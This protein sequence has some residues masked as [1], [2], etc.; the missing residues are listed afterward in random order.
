MATS[1]VMVEAIKKYE[2]AYK[3][4]MPKSGALTEAAKKVLPG[5]NTREAMHYAPYPFFVDNAK[6]CRL[7][8]VDGHEF[9]DFV[10]CFSAT[11]LG[12]AHPKIIEAITKQVAKCTALAA[13]TESMNRWAELI[14]ERISSIDKLR[15]CNSGTEAVMMTVRAAR[16][17]TGK[18]KL[19]KMEGCY[20]GNYDVVL[21]DGETS[22][23]PKG[24]MDNT[25]FVSFNNKEQ[26]EKVVR[27]HKDELAAVIVEPQMGAVGQ[28]PS[29]GDYLPFLRKITQENH[30]LLIF[31]EVFTFRLDY[32]GLQNV[33]GIKPDLT[34]LGKT[35]ASGFPVGA[36]GGREDIMQMFS[37]LVGKVH[38]GGTLN[39]NPITS[40]AGIVALTTLTPSEIK[41]LNRL[42]EKL[43]QGIRDVFTDLK[44][45]SQ[46]TGFGSLMNIH[47]TNQKV[48]DAR[49]AR[50]RDMDLIHLLHLSLI[51]RGLFMARRG[52]L[53]ISVPMTDKEVD[54]AVNMIGESMRE[55]KPIIEKATPHLLM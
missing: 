20:H 7:W 39:G 37:P 52:F 11:I 28:V 12:H 53:C 46:V 55:L 9:L 8:D 45:N 13:P 48:V 29:Q 35:I 32:G 25:F 10:S 54:T 15:F 14:R 31:D 47:F 1:P 3:K 40:A 50:T 23:V 2:E 33:Y 51:K 6:G 27:E 41:R 19:V 22:G 38:H 34:A 30:V 17:Y 4:D 44:I 24:T 5:G 43:A 18:D 49:T 36:F 21:A 16:A 26:V 42:G